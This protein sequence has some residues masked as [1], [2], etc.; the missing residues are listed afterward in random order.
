MAQRSRR[1]DGRSTSASA[2]GTSID[3]SPAADGPAV[4]VGGGVPIDPRTGERFGYLPRKAA[5]RKIII[6]RTLGL[7]WV[8]GALAAALVIV[9]AGAAFLLSDP[10]RPGERYADVGRL[11]AYPAGQVTPLDSRTGWVDRRENITV[12]L[13]TEPFCPADGGWGYGPV[14]W[15]RAGGVHGDGENLRVAD[16][17]VAQGRLYV[18]GSTSRPASAPS[19]P[20]LPRCPQPRTLAG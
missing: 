2:S 7:P 16:S 19:G 9:I 1:S 14:R 17:Q 6:R 10:G 13:T 11:A 20:A 3:P 18:D 8:L 4:P 12:W 5:Q 15:D